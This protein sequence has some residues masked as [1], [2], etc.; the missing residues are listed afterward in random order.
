MASESQERTKVF[1]SYSHSDADWL[2]RLLVHLRP[3]ERERGIDIW[4][5]T[6]I[7]TGSKWRDEIKEAIRSARAI[8]LLVS[9][10][11]LASD[12]VASDELPSALHAAEQ[13]GAVVLPV[14]LS[15]SRFLKTPNLAQFQA[16][17]SP[18]QPLI[19][20]SRNQQESV[21]VKLT[22]DIERLLVLPSNQEAQELKDKSVPGAESPRQL[23]DIA[24][25]GIVGLDEEFLFSIF[26]LFGEPL[27]SSDGEEEESFFEQ[28]YFDDFGEMKDVFDALNKVTA[29]AKEAEKRGVDRQAAFERALK[30]ESIARA[31]RFVSHHKE[32]SI[33]G[34][35]I[36]VPGFKYIILG[37][38]RGYSDMIRLLRPQEITNKQRTRSRDAREVYFRDITIVPQI[39]MVISKAVQEANGDDEEFK[40]LLFQAAMRIRAF[41]LDSDNT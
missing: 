4:D 26:M 34:S 1:I 21:F 5:D 7:R 41:G 22:D 38:R 8:V 17:N 13:D 29:T 36:N 10:D 16:V 24:G 18:N 2:A 33:A 31:S 14:I 40:R 30:E 3:L 9:A 37:V 39:P 19:G 12:F 35:S 23:Q 32:E 28:V 27:P 15:P 11:F 6:K 25:Y 20:M